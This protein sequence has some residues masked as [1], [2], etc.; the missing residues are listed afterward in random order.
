MSQYTQLNGILA[1][2]N[3]IDDQY[4]SKRVFRFK[5]LQ[6]NQDGTNLVFQIPQPRLVILSPYNGQNLF[7][8]IY[9][10][11]TPMVFN[12]DYTVP[13][14]KGGTVQF[15]SSTTPIDGDSIDVTFNYVWMDDVEWDHHLNRA[16]NEIGFTMYYTASSGIANTETLPV[17]GSLPSDIPDG[18][19]NAIC[20]LGVSFVAKALATRFA[21]RYDTSAGDQSFS[22]SQMS[23][24]FEKIATDF[25]K[26]AYN[27]RDDFYRGQGRQYRPSTAFQGYVLPNVTPPR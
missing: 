9:K 17:N 16:A 15:L 18:L 11:N 25:E 20:L 13:D 22:P 5:P 19:F 7:P 23:T 10:N 21:T 14:P 3:H 24:A 1:A 12:T 26:R 6:G 2:R 27:A 4:D 8:Q